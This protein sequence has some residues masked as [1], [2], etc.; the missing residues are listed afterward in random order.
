MGRNYLMHTVGYMVF[1]LRRFVSERIA[2][3]AVGLLDFL[4]CDKFTTNG[5]Q[6]GFSVYLDRYLLILE[7]QSSLVM[8][9][10]IS[11]TSIDVK[12]LNSLLL[13]P[14]A[15]LSAPLISFASECFPLFLLMLAILKTASTNL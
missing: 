4:G 10:D 12:A 2:A 7:S 5:E 1:L 13:I 11:C 8:P 6:A 3:T 15:I 14:S 9:S